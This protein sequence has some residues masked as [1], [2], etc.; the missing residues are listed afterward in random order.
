MADMAIRRVSRLQDALVLRRGA[1]SLNFLRLVLASLVIVSHSITLGGFGNQQFLGNQT[2]GSLA[3]DGFFGI[4]GYLIC[5]SAVRHTGQHGRL[6][7]LGRYLWDR[8][9]RIYPAFWV[10]LLVTALIFGPIGWLADHQSL[11]GYWSH[12]DGPL[13]YV[14]V[15]FTLVMHQYPIS[16]TPAHVPNSGGWDFSLWTLEWEFLC[17]LGIG[18]LAILGLLLRR[19]VVLMLAVFAWLL[20]FLMYLHVRVVPQPLWTMLRFAPIF[21][22]G[23]LL[24]LYRDRV[25]DSGYLA[26]GLTALAVVGL[27]TGQPNLFFSDWLTGPALAYPVLWLGAHLPCRRIGATNDISYGVY[28]YGWAVGQ[29]LALAGVQAAG[30]FPYMLATVAC[31]VPLAAASWWLIEKR[32]LKA[33]SWVPAPLRRFMSQ[34]VAI[35][36]EAVPSVAQPHGGSAN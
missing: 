1:N 13:H 6:I 33:R 30:Y 34:P 18:L 23:A 26:L 12:P 11:G 2:L 7:G 20:E 10:C 32:A 29:L 27:K 19:R 17:Y 5:A 4:S 14:T 36:D 15:N 16:G 28:I 25:P 3:V 22:V 35:S 24:Y 21:M 8:I 31:T 9:L